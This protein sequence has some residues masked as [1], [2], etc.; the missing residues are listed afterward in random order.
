M[1]TTSSTKSGWGQKEVEVETPVE[2]KVEEVEPEKPKPFM[3]RRYNIHV[4]LLF[5]HMKKEKRKKKK[6]RIFSCSF[7]HFPFVYDRM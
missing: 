6:S 3:A 5:Y 7:N 4:L 1:T 2:E